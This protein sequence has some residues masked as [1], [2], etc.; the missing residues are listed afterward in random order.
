M[1]TSTNLAERN[2]NENAEAILALA[3]PLLMLAPSSLLHRAI[4]SAC[5]GNGSPARMLPT[6]TPS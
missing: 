3:M 5:H 6:G 2:F 1:A 4:A